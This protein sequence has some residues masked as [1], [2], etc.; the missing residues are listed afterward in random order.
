M[1]TTHKNKKLIIWYGWN[2]H[3]A[4]TPKDLSRA[5]LPNFMVDPTVLPRRP[6]PQIIELREHDFKKAS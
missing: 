5:P 6:P 2:V 4:P 1:K 3:R